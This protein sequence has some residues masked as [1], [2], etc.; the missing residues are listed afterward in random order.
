MK[1]LYCKTFRSVDNITK[2]DPGS[3]KVV[4][5]PPPL[6]WWPCWSDQ[7]N[8]S[9]LGNQCRISKRSISRDGGEEH[10]SGGRAGVWYMCYLQEAVL[11]L[12]DH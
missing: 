9:G 5:L 6:D 8:Q 2:F 10:R 1:L 11:D 12:F 4:R 7:S 3:C